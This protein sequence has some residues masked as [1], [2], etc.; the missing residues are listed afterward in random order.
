MMGSILLLHI[1][2]P[3]SSGKCGKLIS[4]ECEWA[5]RYQFFAAG[6]LWIGI[7]HMFLLKLLK[8]FFAI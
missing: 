8:P 7:S 1:R 2:E 3:V 6:A 4:H 5:F